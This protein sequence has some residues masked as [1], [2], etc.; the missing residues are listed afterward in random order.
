M[1]R[2]AR[3][4]V[5]RILLHAESREGHSKALLLAILCGLCP[6]V[7]RFDTLL[8]L[9]S[10]GFCSVE[11]SPLPEPWA[12]LDRYRS[13]LRS[14]DVEG[15]VAEFP[16]DP[17][18]GSLIRAAV[19]RMVADEEMIKGASDKGMVLEIP[20]LGAVSLVDQFAILLSIR[21]R[22]RISQKEN[23][24]EINAP[25]DLRAPLLTAEP[26]FLVI[27]SGAY[28]IDAQRMLY[29]RPDDPAQGKRRVVRVGAEAKIF[30]SVKAQIIAGKLRSAGEV[31]QALEL[32][33]DA[34]AQPQPSIEGATT[35][36][37]QK[38][39]TTMP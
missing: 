29:A 33:F 35:Q 18:L 39:P 24:V 23:V 12:T 17:R 31:E 30:R 28:R 7:A 14:G 22:C 10:I 20:S 16:R 4:F 38:N 15:C 13:A 27:D 3:L 1:P 8:P 36:G 32:A 26:F 19:E 5:H 6:A 25:F 21:D 37:A 34:L 9:N 2:T 11:T